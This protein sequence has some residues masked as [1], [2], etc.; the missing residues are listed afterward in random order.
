MSGKLF[1]VFFS[2][3]I[4]ALL[5]FLVIII[6]ARY[7]GAEARGNISLILLAIT[8]SQVVHQVLG[9]NSMIYFS[10][11]TALINLLIPSSVWAI[12]SAAFLT[13]IL[14]FLNQIPENYEWHVFI[15]SV[16][17]SLIATNLTLLMAFE[18]VRTQNFIS[19]FTS[20]LV[21]GWIVFSIVW[22]KHNTIIDYIIAL[23]IAFLSGFLISSI[24]VLQLK[25]SEGNEYSL[26]FT[27][28]K[29]I[30][31]YGLV[32][33]STNV[34]QLLNYRL[35]F[36]IINIYAGPA[37]VG[38][39]STASAIGE[40]VW[41]FSKSLT[42]IQY[43]KVV[44]ATDEKQRISIT[45]SYSKLALAGT[46]M[47]IIPLLIFPTSIYE[48]VFGNEFSQIRMLLLILSPGLILMGF[49]TVIAH[50]FSGISK[51]SINLYASA[52]G[53]AVTFAFGFVFIP[54]LATIGAGI[55]STLSFTA[56]SLLL[57]LIFMQSTGIKIASL[58]P[59]ADDLKTVVN[60][61]KDQ[62][63]NRK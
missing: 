52:S 22:L 58:L 50:Y 49:T 25:K 3:V 55:T 56:S 4:T 32:I 33:Q 47:L 11:K 12:I 35:S 57:I 15:L 60:N 26:N 23:Y 54:M 48:W 53:L 36:F 34:I 1:Y 14:H 31:T 37:A 63:I 5:N 40:S 27:L 51:N 46:L 28:I 62:F 41:M 21:F 38:V 61:L 39:F 43:P 59:S 24:L 18:K 44:N 42:N 8:I 19:F 45:V 10:R 17:Q 7:L 6:T 16:I 30:L 9:G 20:L 13:Y 2:R 29:K